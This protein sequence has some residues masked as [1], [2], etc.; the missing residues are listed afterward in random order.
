MLGNLG[1]KGRHFL[2]G[3]SLFGSP[4]EGATSHGDRPATFPHQQR[5][6]QGPSKWWCLSLREGVLDWPKKKLCYQQHVLK[7]FCIAFRIRPISIVCYVDLVSPEDLAVSSQDDLA[8]DVDGGILCQPSVIL[9]SSVVYIHQLALKNQKEWFPE[10][11]LLEWCMS[12]SRLFQAKWDIAVIL[13]VKGLQG[14]DQFKRVVFD[15]FWVERDLLNNWP[16]L[17]FL[18]YHTKQIPAAPSSH[19][20]PRLRPGIDHGEKFREHTEVSGFN[21]NGLILHNIHIL[22]FSVRFQIYDMR[23]YRLQ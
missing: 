22:H 20:R 15:G 21:F 11:C 12:L 23:H 17:L 16:H 3:L 5:S 14:L 8:C 6:L 13:S 4:T 1:S 18:Q 10:Q 7:W 19:R 2:E 9:H